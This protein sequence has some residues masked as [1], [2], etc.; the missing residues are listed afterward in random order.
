MP[1]INETSLRLTFDV[2]HVENL[3][4]IACFNVYTPETLYNRLLNSIEVFL[5]LERSSL[6]YDYH[7]LNTEFL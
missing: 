7:Y 5:S 6:L 2:S 3:I 1:V 4:P